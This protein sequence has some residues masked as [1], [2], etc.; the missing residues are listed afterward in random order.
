M[1]AGGTGHP[2][3]P[4]ELVYANPPRYCAWLGAVALGIWLPYSPVVAALG[5]TNLLRMYWPILLL[6]LFGY[7]G[8][9]QIIKMNLLHRQWI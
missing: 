5:F 1:P 2:R 9:T 7:M 6:T 8:L 3:R 4:F